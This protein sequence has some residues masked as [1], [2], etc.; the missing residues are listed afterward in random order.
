MKLVLVALIFRC[1]LIWSFLH[2]FCR[3]LHSSSLSLADKERISMALSM[4]FCIAWTWFPFFWRLRLDFLQPHGLT[5]PRRWWFFVSPAE[6]FRWVSSYNL[7]CSY[8]GLVYVIMMMN[9]IPLGYFH[10]FSTLVGAWNMTG[11]WLSHHIGNVII[12]TDELTP[13]FFRGVSSNHQPALMSDLG[14]IER[15]LVCCQPEH[16]PSDQP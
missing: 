2:S 6:V 5:A 10:I 11:L 8:L 14:N 12:P 13:S 16:Q 9:I 3:I 4:L 7:W 1:L 15:H